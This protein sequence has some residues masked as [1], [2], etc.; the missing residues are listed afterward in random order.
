MLASG[1]PSQPPF[2]A[3]QKATSSV[4][5]VTSACPSWPCYEEVGLHI[6]LIGLALIEKIKH[7]CPYPK[8]QDRLDL[9]NIAEH[10]RVCSFKPVACP[11]THCKTEVSYQKLLDHLKECRHS[12]YQQILRSTGDTNETTLKYVFNPEEEPTKDSS[13][14]VETF[15]WKREHFFLTVKTNG[16]KN[17]T[18]VY[19]QMLG[20]SDD[21]LKYRV[22]LSILNKEGRSLVSHN[23]HPFSVYMDEEEKD[24]GGLIITSK[25]VKKACRPPENDSNFVVR[26]KFEKF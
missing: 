25:N 11:A 7:S 14:K 19:I 8:C 18:N 6:S 17:M 26:I 1:C 5:L 24:D 23:D 9:A 15:H 10:K 16:S 4:P 22:R 13:W 21:C 2:T 12:H 3:A 20:T